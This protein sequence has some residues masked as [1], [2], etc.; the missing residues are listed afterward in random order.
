MFR[1]AA[2]I[3]SFKDSFT[4]H[5]KNSLLNS[6]FG[7]FHL[8]GR[9]SPK[10]CKRNMTALHIWVP[11]DSGQVDAHLDLGVS[12]CAKEHLESHGIR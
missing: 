2:S 1:E 9:S 4:V 11:D 7:Y 3:P 10:W 8:Q 12:C 6:L 5:S